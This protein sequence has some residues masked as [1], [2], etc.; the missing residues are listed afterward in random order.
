MSIDISSLDPALFGFLVTILMLILAGCFVIPLSYLIPL[1]L[2]EA[3]DAETEENLWRLDQP[4][5]PE[6]F[7]LT[8]REKVLALISSAICG[9]LLS[10]AYGPTETLIPHLLYALALVL[11]C[12]INVRHKL[13]PDRIVLLTLWSGLLFNAS[14]PEPSQFIYAAALGYAAPLLILALLTK[15]DKDLFLGHGDFKAFSMAGACLGLESLYI[16]IAVFSFCVIL[17]MAIRS[18]IPGSDMPSGPFHLVASMTA[19]IYASLA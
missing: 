13:L 12:T 14:Q 19:M 7:E 10:T 17:F 6:L 11:L 9:I 18:L 16:V 2:Q 1:Q 3:W 15:P 8:P 4:Y 5:D